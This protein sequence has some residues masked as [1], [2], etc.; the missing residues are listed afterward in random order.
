MSATLLPY[1]SLQAKGV[2]YSRMHLRRL[3][4]DGGFP[5]HVRVSANRIAW[6]EAEVDAWIAAR[7][8]ERDR[9]AAA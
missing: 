6:V 2:I 3:E 8:A 9:R 1:N 7:I 4:R 5:K